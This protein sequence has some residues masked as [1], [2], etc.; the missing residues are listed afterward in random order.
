MSGPTAIPTVKVAG[1]LLFGSLLL[2]GCERDQNSLPLEGT[3]ERDRLE[4][5][6]DANE[7]IV[8]LE[9]AEGEAVTT[10]QLLLRLDDHLRS[11]QVDA[12]QA[13][14]DRAAQRL[15]EL[16]RGPREEQIRQ[17]RARLDG[18]RRNL[19]VQRK[20]RERLDRLVSRQLAS[21]SAY[22]RQRNV[23]DAADTEVRVRRAALDELLAGTTAEELAQAR[24]W[25]A[26][27]EAELTAA[28]IACERLAIYAP[29]DGIVESMPYKLGERPQQ[30]APVV[31]ML[32]GQAPYARVFVPEPLR[33]KVAVGTGAVVRVDGVDGIFAGRVRYIAVEASFTPYYALTERDR[34]RLAFLTEVTL[35]DAAAEALPSGVPVTVDFLALH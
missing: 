17:A 30:G 35:T 6:A 29:R 25:L 28:K 2:A 14:R 4:L 18:A 31:I 10:G 16:V 15:A 21:R 3:L 1:L 13:G 34:S 8:Q 33:A 27:A 5:I 7:R 11:V 32:A 26:A 22:D 20:E 24:A 9:V 23:V 12:A 19:V